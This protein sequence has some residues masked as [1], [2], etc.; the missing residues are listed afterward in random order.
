MK[1]SG[2][3]SAS[4]IRVV[5]QG[6]RDVALMPLCTVPSC[7]RTVTYVWVHVIVAQF[8]KSFN[9]PTSCCCCRSFFVRLCCALFC[10]L[11]LL[12]SLVLSLVLLLLLLPLLLLL[13]FALPVCGASF[14]PASPLLLLPLLLLSLLLLMLSL[15]LPA[16]L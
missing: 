8:C 4:K 14:G 15:L 1:S 7:Q 13:L 16:V 9:H 6:M 12:S 3:K 11:A 2:Q 10:L 5:S